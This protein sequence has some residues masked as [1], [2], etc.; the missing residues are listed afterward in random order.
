L[1]IGERQDPSI[2]ESNLTDADG[3]LILE[4]D[5]IPSPSLS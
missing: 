4:P 3:N 1:V 5:H 2:K